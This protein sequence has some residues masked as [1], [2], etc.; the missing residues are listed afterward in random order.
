MP[1]FP[2][3]DDRGMTGSEREI[4]VIELGDSGSYALR[5]CFCEMPLFSSSVA[6]S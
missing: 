5:T 3:T 1:A 6:M 2:T 4:R